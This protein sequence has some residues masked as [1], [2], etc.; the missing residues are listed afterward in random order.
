MKYCCGLSAISLTMTVAALAGSS[1]LRYCRTALL[2]LAK[3]RIADVLSWGW[4][5]VTVPVV[6]AST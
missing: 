3:L 5:S 1:S 6:V 2:L 4:Y